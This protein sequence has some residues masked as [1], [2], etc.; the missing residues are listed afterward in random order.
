MR[1][2]ALRLISTSKDFQA[3]SSPRGPR[4]LWAHDMSGPQQPRGLTHASI[5]QM[6]IWSNA[7]MESRRR[8]VLYR[9]FETLSLTKLQRHPAA[10][11]GRHD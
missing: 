6:E 9:E 2:D 3:C 11:T 10:S 5:H 8:R 7:A 1:T 4:G